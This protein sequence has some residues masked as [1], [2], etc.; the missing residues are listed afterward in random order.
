MRCNSFARGVVFAA[1]AAA[2]VLPWL[3]LAR[4]LIGGPPALAA[5]LVAVTALYLACLTPQP[6]RRGAVLAAAIL[7]GCGIAFATYSA[8]ALVVGLAVLLAGMRSGILYRVPAARAVVV[9]GILVGSGL[10][11]AAFLAAGSPLAVMLALW[12]F[13]LIQSLYF[14]V[15]GTQARDTGGRH[16]DAF[17]DAYARALALLDGGD[18]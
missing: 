2:G 13:L 11:F 18:G 3:A 10:L 17:E 1:V 6:S 15:G 7:L 12:G 4:P 14:L 16:P 8:R 5:Y 9:E